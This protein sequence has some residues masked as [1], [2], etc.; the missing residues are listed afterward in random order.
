MSSSRLA[1]A[2][3]I[4]LAVAVGGCAST[5]SGASC[6]PSNAPTYASFGRAFFAAYCTACHSRDAV[7]R[8]GA[9]ADQNFDSEAEIRAH[10]IEIDAEAA[11]GPDARNTDMPDMTGP[12]H[13]PPTMAER[14][15]LGELLACEKSAN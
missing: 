7:D 8:H 15:R 12:V 2:L 9:P 14:A 1:I 6:P 5:S 13:M 11:V 10:A 3:A 4:A